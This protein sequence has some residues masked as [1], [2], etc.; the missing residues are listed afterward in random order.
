MMLNE[1]MEKVTVLRWEIMPKG[2]WSIVILLFGL[3]VYFLVCII[4]D[5]LSSR[6]LCLVA[7]AMCMFMGGILF[8]DGIRAPMDIEIQIIARTEDITIPDLNEWFEFSDIAIGEGEFICT[9]K[10]KTYG[11]DNTYAD[12]IA[13]L[14]TYQKKI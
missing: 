11:K 3:A 12:V 8:L 2:A 6:R 10:P 7:M 13:W 14:E 4:K 5:W 1:A 9:L